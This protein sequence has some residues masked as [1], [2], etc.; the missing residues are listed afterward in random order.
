MSNFIH[1]TSIIDS[2][3]KL[4]ENNYI[5]PNCYITGDTIIGNNNR[6]EAYCS[7]GT[8]AEHGDYFQSNEGKTIIGDDNIFREFITVNAGTKDTT[9]LN[10]NVV[11]LRGS[12]IGHDSI[13]SN[14]VNISCNVLIGG[15][16]HIMEGCNFG[17]NSMCHQF[18]VIGA[19]AMIGMGAVI[20]KSSNITPG[21]VYIG[22]PA[23]YIGLNT[24]GLQRNN[25][26][27][28]K[29]EQLK[30]QYLKYKNEI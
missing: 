24:V 16:S 11:M 3:V 4:G 9:T 26:G 28:D 1:P 21:G 19:Y 30:E 2:S 14:N 18:S 25:I 22:L 27:F 23:K 12:H 13:I 7:V 17:L 29:L 10:N 5:G 20:T 6:F 8:P 15:H